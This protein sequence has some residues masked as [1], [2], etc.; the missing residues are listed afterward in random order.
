MTAAR[1][2]GCIHGECLDVIIK[3]FF[4]HQADIV[5]AVTK[6]VATD[7]RRTR[8]KA[9]IQRLIH[10]F[11]SLISRSVALTK[12][13]TEIEFMHLRKGPVQANQKV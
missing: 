6:G 11:G 7:L 4:V 2:V 8:D 12:V 1:R 10:V 13:D 9:L 3:N 5:V